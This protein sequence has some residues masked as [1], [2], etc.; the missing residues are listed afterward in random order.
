MGRGNGKMN[1]VDGG[2]ERELVFPL[3]I[4]SCVLLERWILCLSQGHALGQQRLNLEI[5]KYIYI[6]CRLYSR[7]V[8]E[9]DPQNNLRM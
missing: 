1:Q 9:C 5:S 7:R 3:S 2:V 6:E 8:L 4:L